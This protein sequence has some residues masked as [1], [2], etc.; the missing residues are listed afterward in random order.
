MKIAVVED[1]RDI[2]TKCG[3]Y[4]IIVDGSFKSWTHVYCV[5]NQL[6]PKIAQMEGVRKLPPY[7][8]LPLYLS[9]A[10]TTET[11]ARIKAIEKKK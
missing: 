5:N 8:G 1:K 9:T 3:R 6:E 11:L 2:L 10:G 7:V 4:D